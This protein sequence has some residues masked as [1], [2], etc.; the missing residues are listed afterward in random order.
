MTPCFDDLNAK[1]M[2]SVGDVVLIKLGDENARNESA[3]Y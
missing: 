1:R 2:R 3:A